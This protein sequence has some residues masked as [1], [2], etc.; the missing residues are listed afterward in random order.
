M[1]FPSGTDGKNRQKSFDDLK[2]NILIYFLIDHM[3]PKNW[4]ENC[5]NPIGFQAS[6]ARCLSLVAKPYRIT[7]P[8]LTRR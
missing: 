6:K 8:L 5:K 4:E 1:T 3:M 2:M 7:K